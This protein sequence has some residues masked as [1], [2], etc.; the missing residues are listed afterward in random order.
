MKLGRWNFRVILNSEVPIIKPLY[1]F[2]MNGI[3]HFIGSSDV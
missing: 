3:F 1:N 2:V